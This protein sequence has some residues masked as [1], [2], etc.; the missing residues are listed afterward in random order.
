MQRMRLIYDLYSEFLS[1]GAPC[2]INIDMRT[3]EAVQKEM[4]YLTPSR[5]VFDPAADHVYAMLL[6]KDCYPRYIRS[7]Q[8]K[9]FLANALQI[10]QKKR[11]EDLTLK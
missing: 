11:S 9:T 1:P 10:N 2:E 3:M 8:Y 5:F 4:N 6:K 7:D